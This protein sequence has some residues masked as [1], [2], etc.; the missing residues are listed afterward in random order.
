MDRSPSV[1]KLVRKTSVYFTVRWSH[2]KKSNKYDI[3]RSV[4]AEAGIYELYYMDEKEK[5]CLFHVGKSWYGGL[6]SE[7]RART[8]VELE[9]DAARKAILDEHDCWYRWTLISNSD[10]MADIVFFFAQ[11]YLPGTKNVHHS[12]RYENIYVKEI[13]ADKIVTI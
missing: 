4:P 6:R 1:Q 5:L 13:D 10:D 7:L 2:L 12:G 11:T 3:V 9:S 8:D